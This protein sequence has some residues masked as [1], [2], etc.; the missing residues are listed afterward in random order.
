MSKQTVGPFHVK[1]SVGSVVVTDNV[2][3]TDIL[4]W[5]R[6][7]LAALSM[8]TNTPFR[9]A[10]YETPRGFVFRSTQYRYSQEDGNTVGV[11]VS[12]TTAIDVDE[13]KFHKTSFTCIGFGI[14]PG[15]AEIVINKVHVVINGIMRH[16]PRKLSL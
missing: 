8:F 9:A 16:A 7:S 14:D 5:P 15:L 3:T 10:V 6:F 12:Y 11:P 1:F 2:F 4:S 13:S